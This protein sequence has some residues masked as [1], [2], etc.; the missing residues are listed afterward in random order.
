[1]GL[2]AS[3]CRQLVNIEVFSVLYTVS[4]DHDDNM[5]DKQKR[6]LKK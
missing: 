5:S 2:D 6:M 1:M 3:S 4:C